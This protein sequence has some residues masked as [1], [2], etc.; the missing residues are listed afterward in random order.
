MF[1]VSLDSRLHLV[2]LVAAVRSSGGRL[3]TWRREDSWL[4]LRWH[5][6]AKP[7]NMFLPEPL[8]TRWGQWPMRFKT[9]QK[10]WLKSVTQGKVSGDVS[11][12]S[13]H[14][15]CGSEEKHERKTAAAS[16]QKLHPTS[17]RHKVLSS[18]STAKWLKE[19]RHTEMAKQLCTARARWTRGFTR[20]LRDIVGL[21]C[22]L[23][24][25]SRVV[26][27]LDK[28][29]HDGSFLLIALEKL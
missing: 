14:L 26:A 2:R 21:G 18:S 15:H 4:Q 16:S 3:A 13:D 10:K 6:S 29:S 17:L 1:V 25:P 7:R 24:S 11:R 19:L 12:D 5:P 27:V 20:L 28:A 9:R 22:Q 8:R 23:L